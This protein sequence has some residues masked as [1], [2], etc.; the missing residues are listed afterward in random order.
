MN[1]GATSWAAQDF[2]AKALRGWE[3]GEHAKKRAIEGGG[4]VQQNQRKRR[5]GVKRNS[6]IESAKIVGVTK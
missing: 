4:A 5:G 3:G 2:P 6:E 1:S